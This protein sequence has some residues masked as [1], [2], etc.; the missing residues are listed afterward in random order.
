M[1]RVA[2]CVLPGAD[3]TAAEETAKFEHPSRT[4]VIHYAGTTV[5]RLFELHPSLLA[6][7]GIEGRAVLFDIDLRR[8]LELWSQHQTQYTAP[9]KYPTS[10]FDLSVVAGLKTPVGEIAE[11][12]T[13]LAGPHLA[14]ID[15]VRQ[16]EGA[17]L[18]AG[19]KSVS[20][21]L[22]VGAYD[23]T[24]TSEE[25]SAIREQIVQGMREAG[26][27]IRGVG[28]IS[29]KN[30]RRISPQ[31]FTRLYAVSCTL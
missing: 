15:F 19:Q 2:E 14:T 29:P 12:L 31:S 26:F 16:Y 28:Q 7:E 11:Q 3:L 24:L 9:R 23:H 21:H 6:D 17:P 13:K 22:E 5:G 10:G 4:A 8:C 25:A 1:K 30:N 20:F 18:P 27:E